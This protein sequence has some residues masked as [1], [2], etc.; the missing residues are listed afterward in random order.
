VSD[1]FNIRIG[2]CGFAGSHSEYIKQF[3]TVEIQQTFYEP[4]R[5]STAQR[6]RTEVPSDF[7]FTLKAWQLITHE[8]TSATYRRLHTPLS[9]EAKICVGS[10]KPTDD[11]WKAWLRTKEIAISLKVRVVVFQCPASF[12]PSEKNKTNLR[13]FF[14]SAYEDARKSDWKI[15]FGWEPRGEWQKKEIA[16]LCNDLNL[17]H[18]VDPFRHEPATS[19]DFST[20]GGCASGAY[21][22]LHGISSYRHKYTDKELEH[23]KGI[24]KTRKIGYCMFNNIFMKEDAIRFAQMITS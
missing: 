6:W 1:E 8:A 5:L 10:F 19:G 12:E 16:S 2:C 13:K 14:T 20:E 9:E 24:V 18:I 11:V 21:F 3:R 23:L 22:R 17:I 15:S 4:P 7:E